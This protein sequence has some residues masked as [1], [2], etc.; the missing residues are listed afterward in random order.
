MVS[1]NLSKKIGKY[2]GDLE[3]GLD[4][5]YIFVVKV[6]LKHIKVCWCFC[7]SIHIQGSETDNNRLRIL[8]ENADK[9]QTGRKRKKQEIPPP[10]LNCVCFQYR[11]YCYTSSDLSPSV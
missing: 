1:D 10:P 7:V 8:T 2:V 3:G 11:D 9:Q 5:V 4:F 6:I